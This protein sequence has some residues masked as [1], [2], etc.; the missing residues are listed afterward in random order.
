M[1]GFKK[2]K[3]PT[4]K[5]KK[6]SKRKEKRAQLDRERLRLFEIDNAKN[7]AL[8]REISTGKRKRSVQEMIDERNGSAKPLRMAKKQTIKEEEVSKEEKEEVVEEEEIA[9]KPT[10]SLTLKHM[11]CIDHMRI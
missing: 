8:D 3:N 4:E 5:V 9:W 11:V 10:Y 7:M 6:V 2:A 1:F